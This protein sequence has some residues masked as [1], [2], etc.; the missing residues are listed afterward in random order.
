M[1]EDRSGLEDELAAPI[2]FGQDLRTD[3]IGGHQVGGELD[4]LEAQPEHLAGGFD[5]Q[6]LAQP[7]NAFD[8]NMASGEQRG[9]K[10]SHHLTMADDYLPDFLFG[11]GKDALEFS[12][13]L[14]GRLFRS[15]SIRSPLL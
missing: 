14:V 5:H 15:R 7:G 13:A 1:R 4:P 3:D 2:R 10:F 9:E 8:Q 11:A 12:D 6:R